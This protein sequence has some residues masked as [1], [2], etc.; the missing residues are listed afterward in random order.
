VSYEE[1]PLFA[2]NDA[3][4]RER[5]NQMLANQSYLHQNRVPVW[6][7]A[8]GTTR[9]D[10]LK[11]ATGV[12]TCVT[13]TGTI[14]TRW[15][16]MGNFFTPGSAIVPVASFSTLTALRPFITIAERT[17]QSVKMD[18]SGF[19]CH[20]RSSDGTRL[21]GPNYINWICIGY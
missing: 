15:I 3:I 14:R 5:L 20:V 1:V 2:N 16:E 12:N 21:S 10:N 18:H 9:V 11:I 13:P 7:R 17:R 8:Y 6:Y 19:S 4:D